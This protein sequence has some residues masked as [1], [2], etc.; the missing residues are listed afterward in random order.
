M[1]INSRNKG[2]KG[3]LELCHTLKE[4]FG[5]EARR[6]QQHCG[7]GGD[8]DVVI[9]GMEMAFPEVKRVECLNVVQAMDK[10]VS[11]SQWKTPLLFHRKNRSKVGWL[12]T[13][14]LE[15]L[16]VLMDMVDSMPSPQEQSDTPSPED[17]TSS[18]RRVLG[19]W[20]WPWGTEPRSTENTT[21]QK[22]CPSETSSVTP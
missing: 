21:G 16:M 5:W 15:D 8:A 19:E 11:Q 3:E 9:E 22:D 4:L 17:T 7:D 1:P 10:A 2:K 12:L 20:L 13:I 14:R 18:P 6:S